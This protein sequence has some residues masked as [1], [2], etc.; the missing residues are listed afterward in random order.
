ML[1]TKVL[2]LSPSN[3]E[4]VINLF[5]HFAWNLQSSQEINVKNSRLELRGDTT[6]CIT[7]QDIYVKV[8]LQRDMKI[9]NYE[10]IVALEKTYFDAMSRKPSEEDIE[11]NIRTAIILFLLGII[12]GAIYLIYKFMKKMKA[13][14]SYY[15]LL[16]AWQNTYGRE[17]EKALAEAVELF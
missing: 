8:I 5:S 10:K 1:E 4:Y 16:T 14:K 12:P 17:A 13:N 7:E 6:Y 3:E 11:V 15:E 9:A 2:T